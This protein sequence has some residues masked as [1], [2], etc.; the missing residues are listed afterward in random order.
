MKTREIPTR[1]ALGDPIVVD[2]VKYR[3]RTLASRIGW[4]RV[5]FGRG[6]YPEISFAIDS[7]TWDAVAGVWRVEP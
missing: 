4:A 7:L 3:I 2:G 6:T 5:S 1:P